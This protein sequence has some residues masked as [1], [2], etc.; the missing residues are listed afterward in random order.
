MIGVGF[1]VSTW[2]GYGCSKVPETNALSWRFP[3]AFQTLPCLMLLSGM[4]FFPEA[5]R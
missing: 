1:I 5:S 4:M 3:L 2:I